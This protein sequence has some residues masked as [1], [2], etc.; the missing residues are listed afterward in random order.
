MWTEWPVEDCARS[1]S[2]QK[3]TGNV[4]NMARIN[5]NI[6][7]N[8]VH[9]FYRPSWKAAN[10]SR[11]LGLV[12]EYIMLLVHTRETVGIYAREWRTGHR[13]WRFTWAIPEKKNPQ[14]RVV[15]M[16]YWFNV[17][18]GDYYRNRGDVHRIPFFFTSFTSFFYIIYANT[19]KRILLSRRPLPMS[20]RLLL[21]LPPGLKFQRSI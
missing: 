9:G 18:R 21:W 3:R 13:N 11:A 10:R 2:M 6:H 19:F 8:I 7:I 14:W 1:K 15:K 17:R 5:A 4:Q 12:T 16:N 20:V